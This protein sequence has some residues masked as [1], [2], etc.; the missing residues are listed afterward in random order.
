VTGTDTG[1]GKTLVACALL[2]AFAAR[3]LR[4]VGMKP[5]AAGAQR[6][7]GELRSEDAAQLAAAGS[8]TAPSSLTNPYCFELPIAPHLAARETGVRIEFAPIMNAYHALARLAE[9]VVVEGIGGFSVPLNDRDD[10]A[11]LAAQLN[12]PVILVV[13]MRLG[14]LNHALL[15]AQAIRARALKLA[16]W[17]ANQVDPAMAFVDDNAQALAQRLTAPRIAQL[18]FFRRCDASRCAALIDVDALIGAS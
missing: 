9:V 18:P 11:D 16:G 7:G 8:V 6:S 1:A 15:T 5:V 4:A 13:G 3:G 12:L 10:T 2:H 17:V 14:C